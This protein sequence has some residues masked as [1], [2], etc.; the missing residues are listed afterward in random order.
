MEEVLRW[1]GM[2]AAVIAAIIVSARLGQKITGIGFVV[3]LVSST[4]WVAVG[5]MAGE[6]ALLIQNGVLTIVNVV[7]IWRWLVRPALEGG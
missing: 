6:H 5:L 4:A 7:G 3:F 2:G 1:L